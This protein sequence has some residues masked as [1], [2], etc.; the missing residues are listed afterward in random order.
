[1][2]TCATA[3]SRKNLVLFIDG[4]WNRPAG[5]AWGSDTNV[6]RL[7]SACPDNASQKRL[8]L[9]GVGTRPLS[10]VDRALGGAFGR[11]AS[12]RIKD[13]YRFLTG[14]YQR[15]D[16]IFVFGFSR[17]AFA[18]RSLANFLERVGLLLANHIDR[19]DEAYELYEGPD[20]KREAS[21][22]EMLQEISGSSAPQAER[23]DLPIHFIGVWDTVGALGLRWCE[24]T[25][26]ARYTEYHRT[27][28]PSNV[29]KARHALAVHEL[30]E[31]F[32]PLLWTVP[33]SSS[34]ER[35]K[36]LWFAGAH[37]DVGGGY[38]ASETHWSDQALR[39]MKEEAQDAGLVVT[40][41]F[42]KT[43]GDD[44]SSLH[45]EIKGLF[46]FVPPTVRKALCERQPGAA[47]TFDMRQSACGWRIANS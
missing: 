30:R 19:V 39:W 32:A 23:T 45:H 17:G 26:P 29:W 33:A 38:R 7:F 2:S 21:L 22:A 35:L 40:G 41:D 8:Y 28:L 3:A 43:A 36:Q 44:E 5:R 13:C 12:S 20:A 14:N 6:R 27:E 25:F 47:K 1:M 9:K 31:T 42:P 18:A 4:T 37:A 10:M 15:G 16:W 34:P 11:G 46:R 24:R